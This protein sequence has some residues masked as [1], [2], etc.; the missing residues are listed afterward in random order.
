VNGPRDQAVALVTRIEEL[1]RRLHAL[2]DEP[3]SAG[4]LHPASSDVIDST[5]EPPPPPS[6]SDGRWFGRSIDDVFELE[7]RIDL[8]RARRLSGDMYRQSRAGRRWFA[9]FATPP[10]VP[11]LPASASWG[12]IFTRASERQLAEPEGTG[13]VAMSKEGE[14]SLAKESDWAG[15]AL[16]TII[17]AEP[18]PGFPTGI[19]VTFRLEWCG[20]ALRSLRICRNVPAASAD[21]RSSRSTKR[22]HLSAA[23]IL[24][25]AGLG[26]QEVSGESRESTSRP[27]S[28]V[29]L[30]AMG[31][32]SAASCRARGH[33]ADLIVVDIAG[34]ARPRLQAVR[35]PRHAALP[36]PVLAVTG[37]GLG[38]K[39]KTRLYAELRG[40]GESLGLVRRDTGDAWSSHSV[41]PM[42]SP[43]SY[44]H[45]RAAYWSRFDGQ[46]EAD[47]LAFLGHAPL[48]LLGDVGRKAAFGL[49]Q[50]DVVSNPAPF[51][52]AAYWEEWPGMPCSAAP[53]STRR[54]ELH[55]EGPASGRMIHLGQ[56]LFLELRLLNLS[57]EELSLDAA[58]LDLKAGQANLFARRVGWSRTQLFER[59]FQPIVRRA[60]DA[61][62]NP[63]H[64]RGG[65]T[66]GAVNMQV[67]YG[68]DGPFFPEPG[69]YEIHATVDL[70]DADGVDRVS[71]A[72]FRIRV[73]EPRGLEATEETLR[74][75]EPDAGFWLAL[76]GFETLPATGATLLGIAEQ[77][78][79]RAQADGIVAAI[80][81][82]AAIDAGRFYS[83]RSTSAA[84]AG[85]ERC[86][87]LF[88]L[89]ARDGGLINF[90]TATSTDTEQLWH[91]QARRLAGTRR[92]E[93]AAQL[94]K[95]KSSRQSSRAPSS[96]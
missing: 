76:G 64:I 49:F 3:R 96:C 18:L 30:L 14:A 75:L 12:I 72:P 51:G 93:G 82:A 94:S 20:P 92:E 40:V 83:T 69:I 33:D 90:D 95:R 42:G 84:E 23:A 77:R 19:T 25:T 11:L 36:D 80:R 28:Q 81:R 87:E 46:F 7:L 1:L 67:G 50:G 58:I 65:E 4:D 16:A 32:E 26:V 85:L 62:R 24:D 47:E 63:V 60:Y 22:P 39:S 66:S 9:S 86:V 5:S 48:P 29:E 41:S 35:F 8:A 78:A 89:L 10:A 21:R 68:T 52:G 70:I 74:L 57:E 38:A 31:L 6:F 61:P 13:T 79:G 15:P 45:G 34:T 17:A 53:H 37:R 56:P 44:R 88:D 43:V 54:V 73:E 27:A 59:R 71:S 55:I 2:L 91:K